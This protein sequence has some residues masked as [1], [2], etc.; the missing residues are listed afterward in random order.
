MRRGNRRRISWSKDKQ[1]RQ[2]HVDTSWSPNELQRVPPMSYPAS[3]GRTA[4][5]R[6]RRYGSASTSLLAGT[7]DEF[8]LG[9][10]EWTDD[11]SRRDFL[12]LAGAT[13]A[14]A[15]LGACTKQPLEKIVPYVKQ[16]EIVIPGKPLRFATATHYRR[17]WAGVA[18]HKLT[19]GRPTKIEGNPTIPPA[20]ARRPSG[21]R[22]TFSIFTIRIA[23]KRSRPVARSRQLA[24]FG[25]RSNLAIDPS[26]QNGGAALRILSRTVS[27]PTLL[28][29]LDRRF[30]KL[31]RA[32]AGVFGIRSIATTPAAAKSIYD[33]SKAKVVVAFDSDFL[34]PH[35]H[36][37]RYAR[38]F[39]NAPARD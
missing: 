22:P 35:P 39:A 28:A 6:A 4:T 11:L 24:I 15:G 7:P 23:R 8:R 32:H 34:Y 19:K 12:R 30:T 5:A 27:S 31:S 29:Q 10:S 2:Y 21:P 13:L 1:I 14:L 36:A 38:D 37:L 17:L 16:P 26:K 3:N 9:A 33:F 18:G 20:L 25:M